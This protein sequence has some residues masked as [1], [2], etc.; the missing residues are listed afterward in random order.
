MFDQTWPLGLRYHLKAALLVGAFLSP[1][2]LLGS[3]SQ[4]H[5]QSFP[6]DLWSCQPAYICCHLRHLILWEDWRL[7]RGTVGS[8]G[9]FSQ[10]PDLCVETYHI[11]LHLRVCL[12]E[13][14]EI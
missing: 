1:C 3:L 8:P 11:C 12:W 4:G 9:P 14:F 5:S 2:A 13:D 7:G 6:Q 10:Q